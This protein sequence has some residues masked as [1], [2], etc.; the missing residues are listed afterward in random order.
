MMF[1]ALVIQELSMT[2]GFHAPT[3]EEVKPPS[4]TV[5]AGGPT[6]SSLV[7]GTIDSASGGSHP[8]S[9]VR[10]DS[11]PNSASVWGAP[12][13]GGPTNIHTPALNPN[14]NS[15]NVASS[16]TPFRYSK[17]QLLNVWKDGGGRAPLG[18]EVERWPGIVRDTITEPVGLREMSTEERKACM[19]VFRD[20]LFL[21]IRATTHDHHI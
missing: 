15:H 7:G 19:R 12:A 14:I 9:G 1:A 8:S 10:H 6:Y 3:T 20:I 2:R 5:N 4:L 21:I 11:T 18:L 17:E 13:G 16:A